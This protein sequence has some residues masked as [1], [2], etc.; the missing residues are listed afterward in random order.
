M[1]E[2]GTMGLEAITQT[3][4]NRRKGIYT[5]EQFTNPP[6]H[7]VEGME[8]PMGSVVHYLPESD[9]DY[10]PDETWWL[11]RG[12][13]KQTTI[14]VEHVL[15]FT[16]YHGKVRN[17]P[18]NPQNWARKWHMKH[19]T[20]KRVMNRKTALAVE[21][22]L[23][24]INHALARHW[25]TYNNNR[26]LG[27]Q[28]AKNTRDNI[29][30]EMATL[31][32]E[33]DRIHFIPIKMPNKL[34]EI[35]K[36]KA[37]AKL[38]D[39]LDIMGINRF[40]TVE[41]LFFLELWRFMED[42]ESSIF[43]KIPKEHWGR[44]RLLLVCNNSWFMLNL[45]DIDQWVEKEVEVVGKD[46]KV[47]TTTE[48][49]WP[50]EKAQR[51]LL[52]NLIQLIERAQVE[53][54]KQE[55]GEELANQTSDSSGSGSSIINE[56]SPN[57][58]GSLSLSKTMEKDN[59]DKNSSLPEEEGGAL[60]QT[61]DQSPLL[62]KGRIKTQP[63]TSSEEPSKFSA[64]RL[65]EE[66]VAEKPSARKES[67]PVVKGLS[68]EEIDS[69]IEALEK[70]DALIEA[71]AFEVS[72][73]NA[74]PIEEGILS[75]ARKL[76][77]DGLIS[78]A[79][80]RQSE[81]L[82][83]AYKDI[84]NPFGSGTAFEASKVTP[85]ER[86]IKPRKIPTRSKRVFEES[87]LST[88][89][90]E[91]NTKYVRETYKKDIFNTLLTM[92]RSG[93]AL[94][95]MEVDVVEN[96]SGSQMVILARTTP[97]TGKSSTLPIILPNF[98]KDGTYKAGGTR[99]RMKTQRIDV[100]IRLVRPGLVY[101]TSY[102]G[103]V[104]VS[105]SDLV[106]FNYDRWLCNEI[107]KLELEGSPLIIS[108]EHGNTFDQSLHVPKAYSTLS[109]RFKSLQFKEFT[110]ILDRKEIERLFS[111]K[112][113]AQAG[114]TNKQII[115][116]ISASNKPVIMVESGE[117]LVDGKSMG[118][119]EDYLG[120][121]LTEAPHAAAMVRIR[122]QNLPLGVVIAS[123]I[124]LSN[125]L[126]HLGDKYRRVQAGNRMNL[127]PWETPIRFSDES[128]IVDT[129]DPKTTMLMMGFKRYSK[130][131]RQLSVYGFDQ[132]HSYQFL[133]DA[134][135]RNSANSVELELLDEQ[136]VDPM[137]ERV[138]VDMKEPTTWRGLLWR[139]LELILTD[140]SPDEMDGSKMQFKL[141]ERINGMVYGE[142]VKTIRKYKMDTRVTKAGLD[143]KPTAVWQKITSDS[144]IAPVNDCN[145]IADLKAQEA[146]TYIGHGGRSKRSMV[147]RHRKMHQND[148][149]IIGEANVDSGDTGI[150]ISFSANPNLKNTS[151][152]SE[153]GNKET[154]GI[155]SMVSTAALLGPCLDIDDQFWIM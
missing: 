63:S 38:G 134:A 80:L 116:G 50:S 145:P 107:A 69:N 130:Q 81:K 98:E 49:K 100:P 4:F 137:T 91:F 105:R 96:M 123:Y 79:A 150:N 89:I 43:S 146:V 99:Y 52:S 131:I 9:M 13:P 114:E 87:M 121:D 148:E 27:Y 20:M 62:N 126:R 97:L 111:N 76:A 106:V 115:C 149:G 102:Y 86:E 128:I 127:E 31:V 151:G 84:K 85:E 39:N 11:L 51:I 136:F 32:P 108:S 48:G 21:T 3:A 55:A 42:R 17:L 103:K 67:T 118:R 132:P 46:G 60:D 34:Y 95:D 147:A 74:D 93:V 129:R 133:L 70:V 25:Y 64:A 37:A 58:L 44:V 122:G 109:R 117:I 40:G 110:L 8:L 125:M 112:E 72:N 6:I 57:D 142:L 90:D 73:P 113:R 120:L 65:A 77:R 154:T 47:T 35:N 140:Y 104:S 94:T 41:G 29:I 59:L 45:A 139:A 28:I 152:S 144:A 12:M 124:G 16:A 18:G 5:R 36:I 75:R 7:A 19:P 71:P 61:P 14:W 68:E 15:S 22:N 92:Q 78:A 56:S 88:T 33:I 54:K 153:R 119:I 135:S 101:L 141:H 30:A 1:N 138:L 66:A 143:M 53:V 23:L 26:Y 24:V 83:V 155:S 2:L 82:A 10:A